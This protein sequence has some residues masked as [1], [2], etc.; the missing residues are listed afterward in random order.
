[1][2]FFMP[3]IARISAKFLRA[4]RYFM[5]NL[6]PQ[7]Q[8]IW[9]LPFIAIAK[10]YDMDDVDMEEIVVVSLDEAREF[11]GSKQ[12]NKELKRT[13]TTAFQKFSECYNYSEMKDLWMEE[14]FRLKEIKN[15]YAYFRITDIFVISQFGCSV[16]KKQY[17]V[18][19]LNEISS[20]KNNCY[21][22]SR[23]IPLLWYCMAHR[24]W[25]KNLNCWEIEF[26][27]RVLKM[28]LGLD[29]YDYLYVPQQRRECYIELDKYFHEPK[30]WSYVEYLMDKYN[31][32]DYEALGELYLEIKETVFF[33]RW[34][35]EQKVLLPAIEELNK[36][37]ML[38]FILQ[39]VLERPKNKGE[40]ATTKKSYIGKNYTALEEGKCI[41]LPN[42]DFIDKNVT[43]FT[44][45]KSNK[46]YKFL[47]K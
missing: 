43:L 5:G 14:P 38:N 13:I 40:K 10:K 45:L 15:G 24:H 8:K 27:D 25:N 1:M 42:G 2:G 9:F 6:S 34:D 28:V 12:S 17:F 23:T 11:L 46:Q 16:A 19:D 21:Q 22:K 3:K 37:Q 20:Y 39:D 7:Q 18:F 47:V 35:F 31:V 26:G 41:Q 32:K 33:K 30:N 29:V 4:N 36:G 44:K